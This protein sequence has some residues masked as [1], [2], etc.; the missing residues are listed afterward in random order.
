MKKIIN[1]ENFILLLWGLYFTQGVFI[2]QGSI[3]SRGVLVM[4]LFISFYC[5]IKVN[6]YE[7]LRSSYEKALNFLVLILTVYGLFSIFRGRGGD[8]LKAIY[9]SLLPTYSFY[10]IIHKRQLSENWYRWILFYCALVVGAQYMS[11]VNTMQEELLEAEEG[12]T[13]NVAYQIVA[14]LPLLWF[15]REK[16]LVQYGFLVLVFL[17]VLSTAKR[18]AILISILCMMYFV[19]QSLKNSTRRQKFGYFLLVVLFV[20]AVLVLAKNYISNNAYLQQRWENTQAG[21]SSGRGAIYRECWDAFINS[22][23]LELLFGHG[24]RGTLMLTGHSAHNDWLQFLLD[25]GLF[26]A[27]VYLCYW[28][29]FIRT[30]LTDHEDQTRPIIGTIVIIYFISTLFSMSFNAMELPACICLGYCL[31]EQQRQKTDD[32]DDEDEEEDDDDDENDEDEEE[33]PQPD[34]IIF[35]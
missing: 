31:A 2:P 9:L 1:I 14:L 34:Q 29:V 21:N 18:G 28:I 17:A 32:D 3:I 8:G 5:L 30:W 27:L 26:G 6:S 15:W 24:M 20:A 12:F 35:V 25:Y 7:S 33:V 22:N 11:Y 13:I 10:Y 19:S 16:P 23:F 4:Y